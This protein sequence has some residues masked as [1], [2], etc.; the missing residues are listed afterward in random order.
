MACMKCGKKLGQSQ[1]FCDEC[2]AKMEQCPIKPGTVVKLPQPRSIPETKKKAPR[3]QYFWNIEGENDTLR[4]KIR[5]M[6]FALIIAILGFVI[7]VAIIILLLQQMGQL[8][9]VRQLLPA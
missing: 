2:L 6:R 7:S 4:S 3:R 9:F 8:D 1:T 5:W